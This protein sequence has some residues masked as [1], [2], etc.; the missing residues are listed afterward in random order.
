[1]ASS[2]V[3]I[4]LV[5][6]GRMKY[7]AVN[8]GPEG[9]GVYGLLSSFFSFLGA[10][11]Q[12]WIGSTV[13]KFV[14]DSTSTGED[15][16]ADLVISFSLLICL[17][18]SIIGLIPIFIFPD[19]VK[20]YFLNNTIHIEYILFFGFSFLFTGVITQLNSYLLGKQ[21]FKI[22]SV[23]RLLLSIVDLLLVLVFVYYFGLNG[24]FISLALSGGIGLI[25]LYKMTNIR[26]IFN[27]NIYLRYKSFFKRILKFSLVNIFLGAYY[28]GVFYLVRKLISDHLGLEQLGIF[29]AAFAFANQMGFIASNL[30]Y[31]TSSE[32]A[33]VDKNENKVSHMNDYLYLVLLVMTPI[34]VFAIVEGTFITKLFYSNSF[35]N[36][37]SFFYLLI[38]YQFFSSLFSIFSITLWTGEKMKHHAVST[39]LNHTITLLSVLFLLKDYGLIGISVGFLIGTIISQIYTFVWVRKIFDF[40]FRENIVKMVVVSFLIIILSVLL[41]NGA[42]LLRYMNIFLALTFTLYFLEKR[43][44]AWI[45]AKFY[46]IKF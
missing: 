38:L 34:V 26:V 5:L 25:L 33:K 9:L 46:N 40:R 20:T 6:I 24:F 45:K 2:Q 1:M 10:F 35:L 12:V 4:N 32:L 37:T 13:V 27:K 31:Y 44:Y 36:M 22:L 19:F 30:G 41:R 7:L 21:K 18:L 23:S 28:L 15:E 11:L 39:I 14:A 8:I 43:H 42:P 3:V 16:K 17:L 29:F